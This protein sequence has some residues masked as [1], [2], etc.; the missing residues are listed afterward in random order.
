MRKNLGLKF[1]S[2]ATLLVVLGTPTSLK[3]LTI[4]NHSE[5]SLDESLT[6]EDKNYTLPTRI[7]ITPI[8]LPDNS[9]D[10]TEE[11]W[12]R[13]IYYYTIHK[14]GFSDI[15]FHYIVSST[16]KVYQGNKAGDERKVLVQGVGDDIVVIGYLV[17]DSTSQFSA[18]SEKNLVDLLAN[19]ANRN[20]ISPDNILISGIK[21]VK[22]R[23]QNTVYLAS[24]DLFGLWNSSLESIREQVR[25]SYA[26][27]T[28]DY[29]V[30]ITS[31]TI[32]TEE[33]EPNTEITGTI[34]LKNI[35][36]NGIYGDTNA[37][38]ILTSQK[39]GTSAFFL[40]NEWLTTTQVEVITEGE[41]L[42]PSSEDAY[43]F[44]LKVPLFVGTYSENFDLYL[45]DG[46][47]LNSQGIEIKVNIKRSDKQIVEVFTNDSEF[48]NIRSGPSR[49]AEV[50]RHGVPGERFFL[51][52]ENLETGWLEIDL[53]DGRKGWIANWYV[54][55][56]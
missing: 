41:V 5:L 34:G 53:G 40:N 46:R 52:S 45:K 47:K 14:L 48:V 29:Q 25:P 18:Q 32:P 19:V 42:L 24:T 33:V 8:I 30:E 20:A 21:F 22:D 39:A 15:P 13:G 10:A 54:H 43:Q 12:F 23:E 50:V 6:R 9:L 16:G 7:L 31:V 27:Q 11:D 3:A 1:L 38:I 35:G 4:I 28:K 55:Y 44:Q 37:S 2:L 51:V 36:V 17:P 56:L 49:N 26:P